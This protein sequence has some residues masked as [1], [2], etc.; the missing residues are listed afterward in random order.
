MNDRAWVSQNARS[1]YLLAIL[2]MLVALGCEGGDLDTDP[3]N[4]SLPVNE[5]PAPTFQAAPS[6]I[7]PP[8]K[9]APSGPAHIALP[10][11]T[12]TVTATPEPSPTVTVAPSAT[13][14]STPVAAPS[15]ATIPTATPTPTETPAPAPTPTNAPSPTVTPTTV[16]TPSPT[17]TQDPRPTPTPVPVLTPV[18]P[19]TPT[20]TPTPSPE[21]EIGPPRYVKWVIGSEVLE[22]D[23]EAAIQAVSIM[24]KYAVRLGLP[25]LKEPVKFHIFRD[26]E[27]LVRTYSSV[28]GRTLDKSRNLWVTKGHTAM[29]TP[30]GIFLNA[31]HRWYSKAPY[32]LRMKVIAHELIHSF[33]HLLEDTGSSRGPT[34][35][36]EGTAEFLAYRA[37]A[38]GN[39]LPYSGARETFLESAEIVTEPLRDME[40]S[41]GFQK[42]GG[43]GHAYRFIPLA[44][45][46]LASHSGQSSLLSYLTL[47]S[48]ETT[49]Q[50]TFRTAFGMSEFYELY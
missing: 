43:G 16:P 41:S 28:T 21:P 42:A 47:R 7:A 44:M 6:P 35:L 32:D 20:L 18:P 48:P 27:E 11:A 46:P 50:E 40:E 8:S 39:V 4:Q 19:P 13:N 5:T 22:E 45:E 25:E 34:W 15:A 24:H 37:L 1:L 2:T 36:R 38:E 14:T 26:Q 29:A 17:P 9:A 10:T 49:W 33:Q 30:S 31:G 12:P 3:G 23:R